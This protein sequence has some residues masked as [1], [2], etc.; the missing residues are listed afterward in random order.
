EVGERF[1][2]RF[3]GWT[4]AEF[5]DHVLLTA[6]DHKG[7][8]NR[9]TALR[10]HRAHRAIARKRHPNG[11]MHHFTVEKQGTTA[12]RPTT[13]RQPAEHRTLR[14]GTI[15]DIEQLLGINHKGVREHN[16]RRLVLWSHPE[17][18]LPVGLWPVLFE[19]GLFNM[20]RRD[21]DP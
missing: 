4:A 12:L 5:V 2:H 8:T 3:Q 13:T 17:A 18:V 1:T 6:R 16:K 10:H 21:V 15:E 11:S 14:I 7:M 19:I 9:F 20:K